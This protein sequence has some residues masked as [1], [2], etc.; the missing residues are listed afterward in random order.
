MSGAEPSV[1]GLFGFLISIADP[2]VNLRDSDRNDWSL[3]IRT[4]TV[5]GSTAFDAVQSVSAS[6]ANRK[7][8]RTRFPADGRFSTRRSVDPE[9]RDRLKKAKRG[10]DQTRFA[11]TCGHRDPRG[12]NTVEARQ[13]MNY[14]RITLRIIGLNF[15]Y[16][17]RATVTMAIT[18]RSREKRVSSM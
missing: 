13:Q 8:K 10:I 16:Y 11:A 3:D 7:T 4:V 9:Y 17:C 2:A 18:S 15:E 5:H 12:G 14:N 1:V 6:K